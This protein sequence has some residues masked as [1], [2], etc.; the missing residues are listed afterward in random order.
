MR[1]CIQLALNGEPTVSPNPMVGSVV[2]HQGKIIGEGWHYRAGQPHAEVNAIKAVKNPELLKEATL[3]VSL[4][5]CAHHGKTPP[6]TDLIIRSQ[7][8]RV[9]IGCRDKNSAVNGKGIQKLR[10]QNI[11]VEEGIMEEEALYLNRKFLHFHHHKR[12]FITLK[13]AQTID[14]YFDRERSTGE[15]GINWITAPE[16]RVF[17]HRLRSLN[18][19][20]LVGRRTVEVDNPSLGI[21][22]IAAPDP[23]RIILDPQL[24]TDP[25]AQ[26]FRDSNYR[27]YSLRK[28]D[29]PHT[30]HIE[31]E[32]KFLEEVL[33]D[34]YVSGIQSILVEGGARTLQRFIDLKLWDEALI[35]V[36]HR[37][38]GGGLPAPRIEHEAEE[39]ASMG[40]DKVLRFRPQ[41]QD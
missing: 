10:A 3:Y 29:R 8:P 38:F 32:K 6:C 37:T 31:K 16:T 17:T 20:I 26:V 27:L 33:R 9:V 1:R 5:P 41:S 30:K 23:Q 39:I 18:N 14:G 13:W 4:E 12:P 11:E 34:R 35:L 7:I 22:E 36:G 2:V 25:K 19:A 24:K 15:K 21:N 28:S 40:R